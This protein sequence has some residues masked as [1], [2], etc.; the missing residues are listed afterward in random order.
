[1]I[2]LVRNYLR[3]STISQDGIQA[4]LWQKFKANPAHQWILIDPALNRAFQLIFQALPEAATIKFLEV[5][6]IVFI[7]SQG[8]L[9]CAIGG[10][11][12]TDIVL[13]FPDLIKIFHSANYLHAVAIIL[14]EIGHQYYEHSNRQMDIL[15]AQIEA[16]GFAVLCGYGHEIQDFLLDSPPTL[17]TQVRITKL[18]AEIILHDH[19]LKSQNR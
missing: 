17:D 2:S 16:D 13:I 7:P 10:R 14:H 1:M 6:E 15:E 19:Q 18:T 3:K 4:R 8:Q 9:A 12:D 11:N 5:K